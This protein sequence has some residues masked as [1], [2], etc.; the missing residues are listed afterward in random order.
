MQALL[1]LSFIGSL[2]LFL[3][4][5]TKIAEFHYK[6]KDTDAPLFIIY[7]L[8]FVTIWGAIV[9]QVLFNMELIN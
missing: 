2:F 8:I 1:F 6:I 4:A 7:A 3:W 9:I 5:S